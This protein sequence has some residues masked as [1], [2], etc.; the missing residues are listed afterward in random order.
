MLQTGRNS[1]DRMKE[2]RE[3][4]KERISGYSIV[5]LCFLWFKRENKQHS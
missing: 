2:V 3:S 5:S 4:Q 1:L